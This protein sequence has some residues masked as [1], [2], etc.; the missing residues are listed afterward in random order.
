LRPRPPY[1]D[2]TPPYEDARPLYEDTD[3]Q[4]ALRRSVTRIS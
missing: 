1:E 2:N 4:A 3:T